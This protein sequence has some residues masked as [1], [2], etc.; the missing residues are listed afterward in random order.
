M[1][2]NGCNMLVILHPVF[3]VSYHLMH[4]NIFAISNNPPLLWLSLVL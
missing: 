1:L 2:S 4:A 3:L